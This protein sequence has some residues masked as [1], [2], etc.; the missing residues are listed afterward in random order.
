[1][2]FLSWLSGSKK[3]TATWEATEKLYKKSSSN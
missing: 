2:S 3:P 1:M